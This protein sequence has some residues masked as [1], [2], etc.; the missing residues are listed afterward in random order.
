VE[1]E[2]EGH[3]SYCSKVLGYLQ[4]QTVGSSVKRLR[5][6]NN[7]LIFSASVPVTIKDGPS[8]P[9]IKTL[10]KHKKN[11]E[12]GEKK[13]VIHVHDSLRAGGRCLF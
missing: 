12:V 4:G 6:P 10:P 5:R 1:L 8:T 13:T 7:L 2:Q 9:E 11:P 3:R